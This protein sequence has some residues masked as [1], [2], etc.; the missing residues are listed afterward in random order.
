MSVRENLRKRLLELNQTGWHRLTSLVRAAALR[1]RGALANLQIMRHLG[2]LAALSVWHVAVMERS[3]R[4][5]DHIPTLTIPY[6]FFNS[7]ARFL[8]F[9]SDSLRAGAL[10]IWFPYGHA[11][12]PFLVNPQSQLWSPVTWVVSL[13][14]GYDPLI[15]QRQAF[16]ML[17]F[18]SIGVYFLAHNLWARRSS[19]LIAAI[20]FNFTS[21]RLCNAQHLDIIN[22]FSVFPWVFL[23]IKQI[24]DG[25]PWACPLL[26]SMLG[27][28]VVCGYPGIVLTSPL[29]FAG[30]SIWLFARECVDRASRRRFARGLG[31]GSLLGAG[32]SA[33]YWLPILTNIRSFTRSSA[34]TT[35]EALV[36]SLSPPDLWH[37]V[38]GASTRLAS[39]G[40][41]TDISM[42]G[43]YFGIVA[44]A[45]ALYAVIFRRC[46]MTTAIGVGFVAALLMSLGRHFFPRVALHDLIAGLNLSRFPAADS[47]AVAALAGSL[48]AGGGMAHLCE[49][50]DARPRLLRILAGLALLMLVGMIWLK[51][52]IYPVGTPTAT[53]EYHFTNTTYME[54]LVLVVALVAVARFVQPRPMAMAL[55]LLAAFDSGTHAGADATLFAVAPDDSVK[56]CVSLRDPGF[57]HAKAL[58]PRV[59]AATIDDAGSNDA[60]LNKKFYLAS[61]TP[62]RLK[63]LDGLLANGFRPFLLNGQR[64]V[65]F[66]QAP[67]PEAGN[68]F[69]QKA[70]AVE[71]RIW[72]YLP[73]R[74]DY[75]VDLPVRTMLVF[76]EVYF[77]GWRA[78]VDGISAGTMFEAAGGLRALVVEAGH[79]VIATRYLPTSFLVGLVLTMLSWLLTLAWAAG[80]LLAMRKSR[81]P[82]PAGAG[83]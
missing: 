53:L 30:W 60:Y 51:N 7:Y 75:I 17:L 10:P 71:F 31:L 62:F 45:L 13:L 9:I 26:G 58:V 74:V 40:F 20:A 67:P 52:V 65:G 29:W 64:V 36:Q 61:Y 3:L 47:R 5:T 82:S 1:L 42:R 2:P 19:A 66:V 63:R 24:A 59:D 6:D 14:W 27:L 8:M 15:A 21:A 28:L 41:V 43:L 25:K 54:L 18:G 23:G 35:D 55:V 81:E 32:I 76:N 33:G 73:D 12:T 38:F 34:F 16:L 39:D 79:H 72:R 77:P 46:R 69:Q 49:E 80:A 44:F 70:V 68:L 78:G 4:G 48:L 37:L 83:A 57:D 56:R 11:G 50:R 22:A